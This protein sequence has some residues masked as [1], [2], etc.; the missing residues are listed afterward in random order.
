MDVARLDE[1]RPFDPPVRGRV[2]P[3]EEPL[4]V[5]RGGGVRGQLVEPDPGLRREPSLDEAESPIGIEGRQSVGEVVAG[6]SHVGIAGARELRHRG[7]RG[8][9]DAEDV[10]VKAVRSLVPAEIRRILE[11][12]PGDDIVTLE[13]EIALVR[14]AVSVAVF[15]EPVRDG[16]GVADP[17]AIAVGRAGIGDSVTVHVHQRQER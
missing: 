2:L 15:R 16:G 3:L 11:P 17:V 12:P 7:L 14:H 8:R 5:R 9:K 1:E 6:G 4:A 10:Q 13:P